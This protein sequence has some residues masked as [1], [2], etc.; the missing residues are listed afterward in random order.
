M[1]RKE[2]ES[3]D[4]VQLRSM[5]EEVAA[6][7]SHEPVL[8]VTLGLVQQ[9]KQLVEHQGHIIAHLQKQLFGRRT[10]RVAAGQTS[11]FSDLLAALS[12]SEQEASDAPEGAEAQDSERPAPKKKHKPQR[13]RPLEPTRTVEIP[14]PAAE[15]AC[16]QCGSDRCTIGCERTI[17]VEYTPPK[18]EVV[19]YVREKVACKPCEG[20]I[21]L[22]APPA[23]KVIERAMPC[24]K[25][26]AALATHKLVDGLPLHR[27][28]RIFVRSGLDIPVQTLNRWEG[29][30]H[31]LVLP[32]IDALPDCVRA[33][34]TINLDDTGLRVRDPEAKNGIVRGHIWV[35]VG[36]K[37][38]PGGDL[39]QTVEI[40]F[41]LYAPTWEAVHPVEFLR[42]CFAV[43]QGDAYK[44][45]DRMQEPE[46]GDPGRVLAGCCM[47]ARRP[48]VRAHES[49]DP[50]AAFFIERF[51]AIY[52]FE[53]MAKEQGL[54][55][56]E[57]L[58]MRLEHGLPLLEQMRSRANDLR[59]LPLTKP[60]REGVNYL[61]NQW[62]RL[63]VPFVLDGRLE[64]DNGPAERQLRSVASGRKSWLFAGSSGGAVRFADM[65]SLVSTA[66]AAGHNP[67]TYLADVFARLANAPAD[68]CLTDLLPHTWRPL[69]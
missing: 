63:R 26:L 54:R 23:T 5:L 19:E 69:Q 21:Q 30:G 47:H 48:F 55:A 65:L 44:G 27:T 46:R 25:L 53:R 14:V 15:R 33:C 57:R 3:L 68:L 32:V 38:D 12:S 66:R 56:N 31:T 28:Q 52:R 60:L 29:F 13:R 18:I 64:I 41:Y 22:A 4:L 67:G 9:L 58:E 11:L 36:R 59:A 2:A 17:M 50:V 42:G 8:D 37:Y 61:E 1:S 43:L 39:S 45:Y 40:V 24:P 7:G 62:D 16:P 34:D 20:E 49:G 10:E 35:F 51:Q 6:R